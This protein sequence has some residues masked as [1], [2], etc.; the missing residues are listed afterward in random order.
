MPL[1]LHH[2][3]GDDENEQIDGVEAGETGEPELALGERSAAIGVVVGEDVTGDEE[4]HAD[5][6]VAVVDE[7]I[8]NAEVRRREM[9]ENDGDG[10]QSANAGEGREGWSAVDC[11]P[12][13]RSRR[14]SDLRLGF[15]SG[16]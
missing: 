7:R 1:V 10:E 3:E 5:E 11:R 4:E 15:R 8:E 16:L 12:R 2:A 14:L 6:D 13:D 9:K